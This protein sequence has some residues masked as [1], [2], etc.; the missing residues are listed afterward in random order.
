MTDY[1]MQEALQEWKQQL[2]DS[3]VLDAQAA[4]A[5]YGADTSGAQRR[6][7]A[8]L[9]PQQAD[10]IP[11]LMRIAS[12]H[13]IPIHPISTGRNWGYGSAL[14]P[15]Q[16]MV[17]LDLSALQRILHMDTQLG[18]VT[19]EPGVTQGMLAEFL[20]QQGLPYMVP[21]TGAGPHCS[22]LANA[23]ERGYGITP[24]TDHFAAVTDLEA[25]LP[26]G[27][28]YRGAM[29]EAGGD[30][31]GRL[32]RWGIGPYMHGLFTQ[33]GMGVVT[34][35]SLAL[36]RRPECIKV[37]FFS[38]RHDDLLPQAIERIQR[39]LGDLP[40]TIGGLNLMNQHRVL[41]MTAPYP[42]ASELDVD[43]LI[44]DTLL[45]RMGRA[46]QIL[47]WTGFASLY[48][49]QRVVKAAQRDMRQALSGVASRMVFLSQIQAGWLSALAGRL[50]GTVGQKLSRT[51]STLE[52][53]LELVSGTPNETALPLAYWRQARVQRSQPGHPARDGSGL[54]WY[55]PLV[56]MKAEA[57]LRYLDFLKRTTRR[58]G[59][60]PLIT[61]TSLGDRLFDSTVPLLFER[62]DPAAA[63]RAR[64]CLE[65]LISQG[66]GLG[67]HPYRLGID[68]MADYA[69]QHPL[70]GEVQRRIKAALDPNDLLSP[71]RYH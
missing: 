56:P 2:G 65:E 7:V 8:A 36:A 29:R 37:C 70:S 33:S 46:Y 11:N 47:P 51:A 49:T 41:A 6:I 50:P 24:H 66:R 43:G 60:E 22:I 13:R 23:L 58:H 19:L 40:G 20:V 39:L 14:P 21:T 10:Q 54:S 28:L 12:R 15:S 52:S 1:C 4:Q 17:I 45:Q 61:L 44:P 3:G 5:N 31:L 26:D 16:D 18:V 71:G 53:A 9:R 42:A 57:V 69:T 30:E 68:N 27:S 67:F 63:A 34:R 64:H 32:F 25:V 35:M 38:L 62:D 59:M 55:A 48:G